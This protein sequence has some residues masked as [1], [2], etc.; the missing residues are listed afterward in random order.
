M[1]A[2]RTRALRGQVDRARPFDAVVQIGTS[3]GLPAGL[4]IATFEDMTVTQALSLPY[5]EWQ[6]LSKREQ[7]AGV[8]VIAP[9]AHD[10]LREIP[11]QQQE[12]PLRM[13]RM[14]PHDTGP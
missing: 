2:L 11:R 10:P 14:S 13:A 4:R 9:G 6:S 8:E 12:R 5:P 1:A 3:Y 7:A